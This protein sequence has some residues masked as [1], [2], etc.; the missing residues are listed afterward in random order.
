LGFSIGFGLLQGLV[1]YYIWGYPFAEMFEYFFYNSS[2]ARY[3]YAEGNASF[4]GLNYWLVLAFVTVPLLGAFW[5]FGFFKQWRSQFWLF[6]PTMAFLVFHMAYIN[7]QE[8]FIFPIMHVIL[9]LGVM[10]WNEF[11]ASSEFWKKKTRLWKGIKKLS[12]GLNALMLVFA[13]SYFGKKA[14]V[15]AAYFL[16]HDTEFSSAFQENSNDGY[17][18]MMPMHYSGKW[19]FGFTPIKSTS[20]WEQCN[21]WSNR[22]DLIFFHGSENLSE[23]IA[24]AE[25]YL[26]DLVQLAEFQPSWQDRIIQWMNPMNRNDAIYMYRVLKMD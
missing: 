7:L 10:G 18:P 5:F 15:E 26:G 1:D 22:P 24:I 8:R 3:E 2:E 12:W 6:A 9:I 4:F 14:R 20:D 25:N 16:Y 13:I 19:D 17:I 23:R 21:E 11:L